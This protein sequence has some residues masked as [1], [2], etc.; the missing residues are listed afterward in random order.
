LG[1]KSHDGRVSLVRAIHEAPVAK[2]GAAGA[3]G[4]KPSGVRVAKHGTAETHKLDAA[5]PFAYPIVIGCIETQ[6]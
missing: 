1:A 2:G 3:A 5:M 4:D 6:V